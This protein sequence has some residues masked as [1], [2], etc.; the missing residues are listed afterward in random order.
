MTGTIKLKV[1]HYCETCDYLEPLLNT[2]HIYCD[3]ELVSLE[4]VI[5]C[6]YRDRCRE[7][8]N[9]IKEE[10]EKDSQEKQGV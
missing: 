2:S 8:H 4:H 10:M 1:D 5:T 3:H 9:R 7:I 6:K